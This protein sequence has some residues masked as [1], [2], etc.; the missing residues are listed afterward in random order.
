VLFIS[1]FGPNGMLGRHGLAYV[2]QA[3]CWGAPYRVMLTVHPHVW[4]GRL[5]HRRR[6]PNLLAPRVAG[7]LIV[8]GPDSGWAPYLAAADVAVVDHGSLGLYWA[9]L[10]RPTVAV[11]A[12]AHAM[13]LAAPIAV[14]RAASPLAHTPAGLRPAV[15]QAVACFDPERFAAHRRA[16]TAHPGQAVQHTRSVLYELL[17]LPVPAKAA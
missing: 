6:L 14:L 2:D 3:L 15:E 8:C 16:I 5:D 11:P 4:T 1:T 7:G 17:G 10:A 9:L 13:N 12:P